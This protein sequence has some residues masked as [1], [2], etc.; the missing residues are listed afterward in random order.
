MLFGGPLDIEVLALSK[1]LYMRK[2]IVLNL[3]D[4]YLLKF[5]ER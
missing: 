1:P 3:A 2:Y 5:L 4:Y